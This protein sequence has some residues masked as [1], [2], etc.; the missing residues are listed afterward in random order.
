MAAILR[1]GRGAAP[2]EQPPEDEGHVGRR[3]WLDHVASCVC[4][5]DSPNR[6]LLEIDREILRFAALQL[7]VDAETIHAYARRQQTDAARDF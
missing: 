3:P 5:A 2:V 6:H 4:S 7:G 1:V